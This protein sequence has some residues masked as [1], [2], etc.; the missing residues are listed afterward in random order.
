[1]SNNTKYSKTHY[2]INQNKNDPT[3]I[4]VRFKKAFI[5]TYLPSSFN[6]H[7]MRFNN[8]ELKNMTDGVPAIGYAFRPITMISS[9]L[10]LPNQIHDIEEE[11][12]WSNILRNFFGKEA[13]KEFSP[14]DIPVGLFYFI[15][16]TLIFA[17]NIIPNI[18]KLGTELLPAFLEGLCASAI[19]KTSQKIKGSSTTYE[20]FGY[21]F[22]LGLAVLGRGIFWLVAFAGKAITS[23]INAPEASF[24]LGKKF[25]NSLH[26]DSAFS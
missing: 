18:L 23:P 15:V 4:I 7:T 20:K 3:P 5:S 9:F 24:H 25:I 21:G 16:N 10:S 6:T 13:N 11:P 1:M 8:V 26:K 22:L 2:D 12:T 17:I 19:E 14:F